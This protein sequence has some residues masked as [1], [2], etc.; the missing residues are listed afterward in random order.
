MLGFSH[1]TKSVD[2]IVAFVSRAPYETFA[3][4]AEAAGDEGVVSEYALIAA[5]RAAALESNREAY[6]LYRSGRQA[7]ALDGYRRLRAMLTAELGIEPSPALRELERRMLQQDPILEIAP[8]QRP[9]A[10]VRH[11]AASAGR[12]AA[13]PLHL[14][15][16]RA[17]SP[18]R[19]AC[20]AGVR[21]R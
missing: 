2:Q 20:A 13:G 12:P 18:L 3:H 5:R 11:S 7:E 19:R 1:L 10:A 8:P 17:W 6:S 4:H 9:A 15:R 14:G 21:A 16:T